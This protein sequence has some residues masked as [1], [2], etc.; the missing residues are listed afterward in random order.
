MCD[1]R[2]VQIQELANLLISKPIHGWSLFSPWRSCTVEKGRAGWENI[3]VRKAGVQSFCALPF[4]RPTIDIVITIKSNEPDRSFGFL[5]N[6]T[7]W[8]VAV[9]FIITVMATSD[10]SVTGAWNTIIT[11]DSLRSWS[12][13]YKVMVKLK[14]FDL[15]RDYRSDLCGADYLQTETDNTVLLYPVAASTVVQ[16][17]WGKSTQY[18]HNVCKF[19]TCMIKYVPD[20]NVWNIRHPTV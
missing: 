12:R 2:E 19:S 20:H 10:Q 18:K 5:E 11:R 1:W 13:L 4:G 14:T 7:I 17:S 16:I 6:P 9:I 8:T 3:V 15:F